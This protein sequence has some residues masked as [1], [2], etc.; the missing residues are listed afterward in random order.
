MRVNGLSRWEEPQRGD[1]TSGGRLGRGGRDSEL[2]PYQAHSNPG[3]TALH[4]Q[5]A[6]SP[7]CTHARLVESIVCAFYDHGQNGITKAPSLVLPFSS[8]VTLGLWPNISEPQL[9]QL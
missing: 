2:S 8:C 4:S 9:P 7:L 1:R 5:E 3:T 6:A